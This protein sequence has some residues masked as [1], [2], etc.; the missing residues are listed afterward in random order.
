MPLGY[1]SVKYFVVCTKL[2]LILVLLIDLCIGLSSGRTL[3]FG[4]IRLSE[5]SPAVSPLKFEIIDPILIYVIL[6]IYSSKNK[7]ICGDT[8]KLSHIFSVSI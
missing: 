2:G 5:L 1:R 6:V 8:S 4:N 3:K 7:Y